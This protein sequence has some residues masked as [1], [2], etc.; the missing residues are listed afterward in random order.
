MRGA[1]RA[2]TDVRF[3]VK[4]VKT[5]TSCFAFSQGFDRVC[6]PYKLP[7]ELQV[8]PQTRTKNLTFPWLEFTINSITGRTERRLEDGNLEQKGS[9]DDAG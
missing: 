9:L 3:K 1:S 2:T 4:S 5:F 8:L 6:P 7:G